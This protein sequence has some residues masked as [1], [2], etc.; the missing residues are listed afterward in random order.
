MSARF[1]SFRVLVS[2][3]DRS[4]LSITTETLI[5]QV[6]D[7]AKKTVTDTVE[8]IVPAKAKSCPN[9]KLKKENQTEQTEPSNKKVIVNGDSTVNGISERNLSVHHN[10]KIEDFPGGPTEKNIEKLYDKMD[11][12][13]LLANAKKTFKEVSK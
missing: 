4:A 1:G 6:N 11:D 5:D 7:T 3:V 8:K 13:N 10:V 12:L 2:T 9:L